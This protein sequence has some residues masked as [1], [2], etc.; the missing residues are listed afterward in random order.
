MLIGTLLTIEAVSRVYAIEQT[1]TLPDPIFADGFEGFAPATVF[2]HYPANGHF[3][4]VRGSG[5]S[6]NW[7]QGTTTA[8]T[9]DTFA[10]TLE[11]TGPI[12]W[13]PLLDD[14]TYAIGPN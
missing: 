14:T 1:A 13:K 5:G 8:S 3:I 9:G 6:V 12:E 2:V 7:T 10:L 11:L 4:T